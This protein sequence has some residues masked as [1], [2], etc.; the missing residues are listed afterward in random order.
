MY[1]FYVCVDDFGATS[2]INVAVERLYYKGTITHVALMANG[3]KFSEAVDILKKC[4]HL[5][6]G[7]H[8]VLTDEKPCISHSSLVNPDTGCFYS[9]KGLLLRLLLLRI[10][11]MDIKKELI[12][13][14][15]KITSTGTPIYFING[16]QHSHGVTVCFV[17]YL[18]VL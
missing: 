13:Q 6:C 12:A 3:D 8:F 11:L 7:L 17:Y 4:S 14:A 16:H 9:R 1:K 18:Q 15:D 10:K 2:G 5:K